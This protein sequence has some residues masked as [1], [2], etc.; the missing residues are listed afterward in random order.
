MKNIQLV[1]SQFP[2][3]VA[4]LL[5]FLLEIDVMIYRGNKISDTWFC[6]Q[7]NY[8]CL[9]KEEQ[10]LKQW[11]PIFLDKQ[12]FNFKD[13]VF[14]RWSH[15]FPNENNSK[16]RVI[17]LIRDGRD[18]IYSQYKREQNNE[19]FI[20]MLNNPYPPF[21]FTPPIT[22]SLFNDLWKNLID[23][24]KLLIIKFEDLKTNPAV[25]IIKLLNFL[26]ISRTNEEINRGITSS[27]FE[28]AKNA[29]NEYKKETKN[30]QFTTVNRKGLPGEW[31]QS[32]SQEELVFFDGYPSYILKKMDYDDSQKLITNQEINL[33]R[34]KNDFANISNKGKNLLCSKMIYLMFPNGIKDDAISGKIYSV[35]KN[36]LNMTDNEPCIRTEM[37]REY[38]K[39][40]QLKKSNIILDSLSGVKNKKILE[41]IS[42]NYALN[43]QFFKSI[44]ILKLIGKKEYIKIIMYE[45]T[46]YIKNRIK[47]YKIW[48]N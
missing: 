25:T 21:N 45:Y 13:E 10:I 14:I 1:S 33:K 3:G 15:E 5:N 32:Y 40:L 7:N 16:G 42:V 37:A 44:K 43:F 47:D 29:E 12:K 31:R 18:A 39:K 46:K 28:R 26:G 36:A 4:W 27:S 8:Y 34:E 17:L 30:T 22:W 20:D 24:D 19:L 38:R 9:K 2:S 23:K 35:L 48:L 41:R 6:D 11:M